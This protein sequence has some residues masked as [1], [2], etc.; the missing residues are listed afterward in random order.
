MPLHVTI[1]PDRE[2]ASGLE[3][4][5]VV[6]PVG[7]TVLGGSRLRH[8]RG[9]LQTGGICATTPNGALG[10]VGGNCILSGS[11]FDVRS[12]DF[13]A[14]M[15]GNWWGQPGGPNPESISTSGQGSLDLSMPLNSAPIFCLD[16]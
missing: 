5:V 4:G 3:R 6:F 7:G 2:R 9:S 10:S 13:S 1:Q 15:R 8:G 14:V 11:S 12:E 16:Q